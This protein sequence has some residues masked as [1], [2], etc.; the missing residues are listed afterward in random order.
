MSKNN[1][2]G[3]VCDSCKKPIQE[4]DFYFH[5]RYMSADGDKINSPLCVPCTVGASSSAL[6]EMENRYS[7]FMV[8]ILVVASG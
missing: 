1:G 6:S 5:M 4:G 2:D 3:V 8:G 7:W